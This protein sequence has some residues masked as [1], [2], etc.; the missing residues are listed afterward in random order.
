MDAK[1]LY[2]AA[3]CRGLI[4]ASEGATHAPRQ[5]GIPRQ[6]AAASLKHLQVFVLSLCIRVFRGNMPRPH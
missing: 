6:H 5:T 3:T 2:S 4:E 1:A